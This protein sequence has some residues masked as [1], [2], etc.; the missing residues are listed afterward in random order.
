[1][2]CGILVSGILEFSRWSI[3]Y[4]V[5]NNALGVW[6]YPEVVSIVV[7]VFPSTPV[8]CLE[9]SRLGGVPLQSDY[10][11]NADVRQ[12]V[13]N[14]I[15][16]LFCVFAKVTAPFLGFGFP[17]CKA[18]VMTFSSNCNNICIVL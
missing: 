3:R 12:W 15:P 2:D 18:S 13:S 6:L 16:D 17:F 1:M 5:I 9:F 14:A 4:Q 11:G 10:S 8:L 7:F